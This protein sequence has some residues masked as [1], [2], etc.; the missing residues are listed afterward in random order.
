MPRNPDTAINTKRTMAALCVCN[1]VVFTCFAAAIFCLWQWGEPAGWGR[2][3]RFVAGALLFYALL[4]ALHIRFFRAVL[5]A[6]AS[7]REAFGSSYDPLM[8]PFNAVLLLGQLS[9]FLDYGHWHLSPWLERSRLQ[10]AGLVL[11]LLSLLLA[12]WADRHLLAAFADSRAGLRLI[13]G[14]PY[15]YIRHPRYAALFL[16]NL[17]L[18]LTL[19]SLFAWMFA[20]LWWLVVWRRIRM[21]ERHLRGM[22]GVEYE[23]Y[24]GRTGSVFPGFLRRFR[25]SDAGGITTESAAG[26]QPT[27]REANEDPSCHA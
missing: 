9:V 8:G 24:A 17:A 12:V 22:F 4:L 13:T 26:R 1:G 2:F 10:Y 3:D 27:A 7:L 14:G 11:Y 16:S 15:Q 23:R 20:A 19:A 18:A 25:E 5:R 6:G 21:E